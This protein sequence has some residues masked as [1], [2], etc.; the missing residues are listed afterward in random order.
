MLSTM[1]AM[2]TRLPRCAATLVVAVALAATAC[3]ADRT[4]PP[5]AAAAAPAPTIAPERAVD[6]P[7]TPSTTA[8]ETTTTTAVPVDPYETFVANIVEEVEFLDAFVEPD[9][10]PARFEFAITNPT[11]FGNPLG[12]MVTD[13]SDDGRWLKVQIPVRPNGT[14]A[15]IRAEDAEVTSHRFRARVDLTE[16]AVTVWDGPDMV[17]E[18]VAVIGKPTTPTPLGRFFVNDLIEKWDTSAYGP[19]ILSLS[20]FS[21]A[22][23]TFAGGIPVIAI[24]GTNRP[25]LMGGAHSNGCIRIPNDVI[26][27]LADT[28]PIGTPVE[29]VAS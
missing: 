21:E 20:G 11:Y 25:E 5:V 4:P 19:Y 16:R 10:D 8:G 6:A 15:W 12:L 28:V 26:R 27:V 2:N 18:T 9:G 13:R 29:I 24:H 7:I 1:T 14:E 23:D 3:G 22:M 17:V